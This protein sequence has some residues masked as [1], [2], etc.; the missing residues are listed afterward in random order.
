VLDGNALA[1]AERIYKFII[2]KK[3]IHIMAKNTGFKGWCACAENVM[4]VCTGLR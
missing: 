1:G 3:E 4:K 2:P